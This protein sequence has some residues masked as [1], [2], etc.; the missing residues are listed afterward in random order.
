MIGAGLLAILKLGLARAFPI[1]SAYPLG[2]LVLAALV[3]EEAIGPRQ[4]LGGLVTL[5]GR[6]L[7]GQVFLGRMRRLARGRYE[8][9]L[10]P[11]NAPGERLPHG[12]VTDRYARALERWIREDPAGWWWSHKRWKL[13]RAPA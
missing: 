1:S 13:E 8:V 3:L 5:L 4:A 10:E 12:E 6:A 11:L 2:T 7:R 9:V